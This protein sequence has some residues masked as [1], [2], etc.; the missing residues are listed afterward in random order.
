MDDAIAPIISSVV[1]VDPCS[2]HTAEKLSF[3]GQD[4][5]FSCA[6]HGVFHSDLPVNEDVCL[7]F[8]PENVEPKIMYSRFLPAVHSD[9]SLTPHPCHRYPPPFLLLALMRDEGYYR[10]RTPGRTLMAASSS[11]RS[12]RHP[13]LTVDILSSEKLWKAWM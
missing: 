9:N 5:V 13:T 10:W 3:S 1:S 6:R 2:T 11:S 8:L 12:R 4:Q 7:L